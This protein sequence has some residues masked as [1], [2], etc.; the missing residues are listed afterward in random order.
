MINNRFPRYLHLPVKVANKV[1][2][3]D[4]AIGV[5]IYAVGY[6]TSWVVWVL[7]LFV[8]IK[9]MKAKKNNPRGFLHHWMMKIG[10]KKVPGY[11]PLIESRFIE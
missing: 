1:E 4:I 6:M 5:S 9:Y 10:I 7:G 11:P 8:I 3:E 2:I